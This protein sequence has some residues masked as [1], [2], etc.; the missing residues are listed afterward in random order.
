[1]NSLNMQQRETER[2]R[3]KEK[4]KILLTRMYIRNLILINVMMYV[5]FKLK[6]YCL[7]SLIPP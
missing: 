6:I 1:M 5:F 3:K 2:K 7:S 4:A